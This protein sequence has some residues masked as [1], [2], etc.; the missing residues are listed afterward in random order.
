MKCLAPHDRP[1]EKLGRLG[2]AALGDNELLAAVLGHGFQHENALDLANRVLSLAG[3]LHGLTRVLD[4]HLRAVTGIGPATAARILAA[5]ELGRRTLRAPEER[6]LLDC[7]REVAAYLLPR[8]GARAVEQF[9]VVLLDAR[10]R[11]VRVAVLSVGTLDASLVHP[12]EV[13]QTAA[14]GG[15]AAIVVFHNHPS[16]DPAPSPDDVALTVRLVEAGG[17]MGI[18]VLDHVVLA[19]A[20]YYSFKEA[21]RL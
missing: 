2:S 13:S 17:I 1:R 8:Y 10:H 11:V 7:P 18:D 9:G 16:G 4:G 12:R 15:A 20:S 19:D 6:A 21:G 5:I 14:A 3:G